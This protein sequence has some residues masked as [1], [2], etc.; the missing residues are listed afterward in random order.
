MQITESEIGKFVIELL[1]KQGYQYRCPCRCYE[2][3]CI[4]RQI[5]KPL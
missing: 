3:V 5:K 1:E 2:Y 4:Y